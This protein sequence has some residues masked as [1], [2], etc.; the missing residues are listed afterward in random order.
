MFVWK[1]VGL[2][3]YSLIR[4]FPQRKFCGHPVVYF[5]ILVWLLHMKAKWCLLP[6]ISLLIHSHGNSFGLSPQVVYECKV[7][8]RC[9]LKI[10]AFECSHCQYMYKTEQSGHFVSAVSS[11]S[12]DSHIGIINNLLS[13]RL[14]VPGQDV[15]GA[16]I[17]LTVMKSL[18][19]IFHPQF[20]QIAL[21]ILG[22]MLIT[23]MCTLFI[24]SE[25]MLKQKAYVWGLHTNI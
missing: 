24:R 1:T 19:S 6:Y 20:L 23:C 5:K 2:W 11:R 13:T 18:F 17:Q 21:F 25:L 15:V 16:C 3:L 10:Y 4:F 7:W 8:L 12:E 14:G 22:Q 9:R